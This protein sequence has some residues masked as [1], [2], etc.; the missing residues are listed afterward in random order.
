[1]TLARSGASGIEPHRHRLILC[2]L[3]ARG[4]DVAPVFP[5]RPRISRFGGH[6]CSP[7]TRRSSAVYPPP[8]PG[9]LG[10]HYRR[11]PAG[12]PLRPRRLECDERS[13]T[14]CDPEAQYG[15]SGHVHAWP[16]VCP[17]AFLTPDYAGI[18]PSCTAGRASAIA[19]DRRHHQP[20]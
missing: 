19:R 6:Y 12:S 4:R 5:T 9:A 11:P 15:T 14:R 18:R 17:T 2:G 10:I 1:M 13:T 20:A 3:R 7:A 16:V 8:I